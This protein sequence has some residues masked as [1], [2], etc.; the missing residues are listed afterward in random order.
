MNNRQ[1]DS[2]LYGNPYTTRY[3]I[4]TYPEDGLV[5]SHKRRYGFITNTEPSYMSGEHWVAWWVE[6]GH[7]VFF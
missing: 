2:K 5:I 4:G 6:N 3:F 1:L 7:V